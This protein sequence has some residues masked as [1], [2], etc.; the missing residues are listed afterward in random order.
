MC[1]CIYVCIYKYVLD[2]DVSGNCNTKYESSLSPMNTTGSSLLPQTN[3]SSSLFVFENCGS[4][5]AIEELNFSIL[6]NVNP[7]YNFNSET[8]KFLKKG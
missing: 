8:K 6:H 3:S 2:A 1:V 4:A 7:Q 5:S